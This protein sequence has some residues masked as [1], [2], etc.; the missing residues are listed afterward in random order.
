MLACLLPEI[1]FLIAKKNYHKSS[2][3]C[4]EC[5]AAAIQCAGLMSVTLQFDDN[6]ECALRISRKE[7]QV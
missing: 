5:D 1:L 7:K 6:T 4:F 3:L 2:S